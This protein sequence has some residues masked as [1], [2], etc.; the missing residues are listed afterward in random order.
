[1]HDLILDGIA[2]ILVWQCFHARGWQ[3]STHLR[4]H[5]LTRADSNCY[6][7]TIISTLNI[8]QLCF[9]SHS[10]EIFN[11]KICMN[12]YRYRYMM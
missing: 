7:S 6:G 5:T 9:V 11:S 2:K 4:I 3:I 8:Y 1:M 10:S 12:I